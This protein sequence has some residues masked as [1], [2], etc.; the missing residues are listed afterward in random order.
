MGNN[1]SRTQIL[2]RNIFVF[3]LATIISQLITFILTPIY[4]RY[5]TPQE[6]GIF[7]L[8]TM[9]I[10]IISPLCMIGTSDALFRLYFDKDDLLYRKE[11]ISTGLKLVI[12]IASSVL[13]IFFIFRKPITIRYLGNIKYLDYI[14]LGIIIIFFRNI[15]SITNSIIRMENNRKKIVQIT[16]IQSVVTLLFNLLFIVVMH[17]D[18]RFILITNVINLI[19][20]F[21]ITSEY[22]R[23]YLNFSDFRINKNISKEIIRYGLPLTPVFIGYWILSAGDKLI[24]NYIY[25]TSAVGLYSVGMK[26]ASIM[27]LFQSIFA[28]GWHFFSFFTMRDNDAS[29]VYGKIFDLAVFTGIS[30][31]TVLLFY[32]DFIFKILFSQIYYKAW[33]VSP[34]LCLGPVIMVLKWIVGIGTSIKKKTYLSTIGIFLAAITNIIL[35]FLFIP[36]YYLMG[37]AIATLISYVVMLIFDILIVCPLFNVDFNKKRIIIIS[38]ILFSSYI[39]KYRFLENKLLLSTIF[40]FI[41]IAIYSI[42]NRDLI[43]EIYMKIIFS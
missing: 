2:T 40:L 14:I 23:K 24:L 18:M 41:Y 30:I 38:S 25:D 5:F 26:L 9:A 29:R 1:E 11:L 21:F 7:S 4:T 3:G 27:I 37:A 32:G 42:L 22:G 16:L 36:K 19:I 39:I 35:N 31:V 13:I 8:T 12:Y 34:I 33:V 17:K 43:K 20:L 10:S 28:Q 15:T 6:F